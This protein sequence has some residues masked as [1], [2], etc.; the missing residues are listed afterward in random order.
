MSVKLKLFLILVL[1]VVA[2]VLAYPREDQIFKALGMK[3]V[4][5][6]LREGLDLKGGVQLVFQADLAKIPSESRAKAMT[7]LVDVMQK[8]SNPGGTSEASVQLANGNRVI[9]QLPGENNAEDAIGR[10]GKPAQLSFLEITAGPNG[11]AMENETSIT[12]KDVD[13]ANVDFDPQTGKPIVSLQLKGGDSTKRFGEVT[14]RIN[15]SGSRL[16]TMLDQD[17]IFGP[18]TV[19]TPITDG[20]A[21]LSGN[22]TVK[23]AQTIAREINDG[24]L[25]V[26][27]SLVQQNTVGPTLGRDSLARSLVAG[28]IGLGIVAIFMIIYY[29][30]AGLVAV[31]ALLI[32]TVLTVALYKLSI[33][34]PLSITL[35]LA[36]IAGFILSIGMA[37]DANILIFERTKEEV[38]NGKSIKAGIE[39]GF[40]RAWSSIRDSNFSTLITCLILYQFSSSTP[41][42]RG[43]AVTLGL[44]VLISMF[45]A[46]I[47]SRTFLRTVV[48]SRFGD[49]PRL[50]GFGREE[51]VK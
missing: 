28:I 44:G 20:K 41:L 32:Y 8:R 6:Q 30:L 17:V 29:R 39:A 31:L 38:R 22:F 15:Q 33:F 18:A 12:G 16:V 36:G 11:S 14:T 51:G 47:V 3:N 1:A 46:V 40:D 2:G 49:N 9:V 5:L 13:S 19:S 24:A 43:F 10:I 7:S 48:G 37:V 45:T 35:T 42:I 21:Q 23:Q 27:V 4:S 26:P 50:F 25:P 34:T